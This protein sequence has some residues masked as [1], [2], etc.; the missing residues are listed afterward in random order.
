MASYITIADWKAVKDEYVV[1]VT[2]RQTEDDKYPSGW[3]YSLHFGSLGGD[4]ILRYD[5]AHERTKGHERHTGSEVEI[6]DFPG[7]LTLYD[8]FKEEAEEMSSVSWDWET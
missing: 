3:D 4:T 1:N 5:N 7:M 2:I 8:R 6:I